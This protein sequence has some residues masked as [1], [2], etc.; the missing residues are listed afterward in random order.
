MDDRI[1]IVLCIVVG[2]GE[3]TRRRKDS[4]GKYLKW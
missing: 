1:S 2:R 3:E 4:N